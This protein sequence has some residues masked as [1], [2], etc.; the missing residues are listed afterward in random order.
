MSSIKEEAAFNSILASAGLAIGKFIAA[1][2]TG[3][4]GL[5]SDALH[6]LLDV[7]ATIMTYFA[8]RIG[9][10]PADANHPYGHGKIEAV[11]ALIE[12][13]LLFGVAAYVAIEAIGRLSTG[14]HEIVNSKIAYAILLISIVVDIVRS[15]SLLRIAKE[16]KSE[17][18]AA[19][20]LH[21]QSDLVSSSLV[22]LGLIAA[23]F[24]YP[25]GDTIAAIGVSIFISIAG[26]RL[27]KRTVDTLMDAVPA[28]LTAEIRKIA[29]TVDGVAE[30]DTVRVRAVGQDVFAEIAILVARTLSLDRISAIKNEVVA[31]VR[32]SYP[33]ASVIVST[34]PKTLDDETILERILHVAAVA[35]QPVHHITVQRINGR[36]SVS[37]DM[38]V[39]GRFTVEEGH[40]L[41]TSLEEAIARE[42]GD[43]I[44]IETHLEPLEVR[45]LNGVD[46]PPAGIRP[47]ELAL[48]ELAGADGRLSA[49]HDVRARETQAG[50]VVNYHCNVP[51]RMRVLEMHNRIDA[52]E[53]AV[54]ERFP[55]IARV[56][57]H[58][59]P[60]A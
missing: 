18:L 36:L 10:K 45:A 17:A 11:A 41:A 21:F 12:T 58:A 60:A 40:R 7:G 22:L 55:N 27:G 43:G 32:K 54:R 8:V 47:I 39:D 3:S 57:G 19:D 20:A 35:K 25:Q 1:F 59:E 15:R 46:L 9:S 6:A 37:L 52:V 44:E 49:I 30:L 50:V 48:I 53:R 34:A 56:F 29:A 13:G 24:G 38:E 16:T 14:A 42:L 2:I 4:L 23:N 26:Y 33:D 31:A 5:L 28:E 51:A